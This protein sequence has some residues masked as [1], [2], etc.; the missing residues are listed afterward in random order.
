MNVASN[1]TFN[2][3]HPDTQYSYNLLL[4]NKEFIQNETIAF[5][6]AKYPNLYYNETK[7]RRDVGYIVDAAATD[8]LYKG[9][10]R[11]A[12][13]GEFYFKYPSIATDVQLTETTVAINYAKRLSIS[14]IKSDVIPTPEIISNT[15]SNIKVTN[16]PQ[17]VSSNAATATEVSKVSSSFAIV[18]DVVENGVGSL[19]NK[20]YNVSQ[21]IKVTNTTQYT[22]TLSGSGIEASI[23]T[24]SVRLINDII[25]NNGNVNYALAVNNGNFASLTPIHS[26]TETQITTSF[27]G[28]TT[29][30]RSL[31]SSSFGIVKDIIGGGL[32]AIPTLVNNASSSYA[33]TTNGIY[34][35]SLSGSNVEGNKVTASFD[36][37]TDI[38]EN[39]TYPTLVTN[40]SGRINTT[41]TA[42]VSQSVSAS[43]SEI[44]NVSSSFANVINI[45]T[46]GITS[47]PYVSANT[48]NL[49]KV[50]TTSQYISQSGATLNETYKLNNSVGIVTNIIENGL[51]AQPTMVKNTAGNIKAT[52]TSVV[53]TTAATST[54]ATQISSSISNVV[55]I[56]TNGVG[57]IPTY[58]SNTNGNIKVTS[59]SQ[60]LSSSFGTSNE[61]SLISSSIS[62]V[63]NIVAN[64]LG[65]AGTPTNYST[66]ST[67]SNVYYAYN[68]VKENLGFIQN[69]TIAY[70]SSSWSTSS[71]DESK[72]RRDIGLII[73][74]A[75]EDVLFGVASASIVNGKFYFESASQA[76][77]VQLNQTLDGLFYAS[78][79]AQK[80]AVNTTFVTA[81]ANKTNAATILK[82]NK[83]FIQNET[84]AYLSSS[85]NEFNYLTSYIIIIEL[86][87]RRR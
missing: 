5:V 10:Q 21:S 40:A 17:Y 43:A 64:G 6:N 35:S 22:S 80:I 52:N 32:S 18:T 77:G 39:Q 31:V 34:S 66:P 46:N 15:E 75:L 78:K 59:T 42:I 23:I 83:P 56:I 14:V 54:E 20:E 87:P 26:S 71:Y 3:P 68:L 67:A 48:D 76:T 50:T 44:V 60:Y 62:I 51:G 33:T 29:Y 7:C 4:A 16:V 9:N 81:S 49:I 8:L 85:W 24:A 28:N 69:E 58:V 63:T 30:E 41:G 25:N 86:I 12:T 74:G 55:N 73:S 53:S 61:A 84:I 45:I 36:I 37:V 19:P 65:V 2:T 13:A 79:L 11:A 57:V 1:T 82:N 27:V 47:I 72:C 38:I 70:L